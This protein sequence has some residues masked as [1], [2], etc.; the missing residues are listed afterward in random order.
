MNEIFHTEAIQE[1]GLNSHKNRKK[2]M[3]CITL[4]LLTLA[5]LTMSVL[6]TF[7][8]SPLGRYLQS[9]NWIHSI[10]KLICG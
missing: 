7:G 8:I 5:L 3:C 1:N 9:V 2:T 6:L 10:A 4:V